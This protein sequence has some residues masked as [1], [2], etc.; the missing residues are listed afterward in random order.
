MAAVPPPLSKSDIRFLPKRDKNISS[1]PTRGRIIRPV[2]VT[3][4]AVLSMVI[5]QPH[6]GH[7]HAQCT[8]VLS[9]FSS[10]CIIMVMCS[11]YVMGQ[12]WHAVK[13]YGRT[14]SGQ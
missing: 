1:F 6:E 10:S 5:S 7:R 11:G 9:S 13:I 14:Q 4:P 3:S 2:E 8:D 12:A